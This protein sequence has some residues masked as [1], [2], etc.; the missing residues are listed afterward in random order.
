LVKTHVYF[1]DGN[2]IRWPL[3]TSLISC[4][5]LIVWTPSLD[6]D[7]VPTPKWALAECLCSGTAAWL[8]QP[9]PRTYPSF[10]APVGAVERLKP[11]VPKCFC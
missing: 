6:Y 7:F 8:A 9:N 3:D 4:L 1:R 2:L 11:D 5:F 10:M